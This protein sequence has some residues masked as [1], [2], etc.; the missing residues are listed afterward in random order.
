MLPSNIDPNV[1]V[2]TEEATVYP[3]HSLLVTECWV[4]LQRLLTLQCVN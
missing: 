3:Q 2:A 4:G 1:S